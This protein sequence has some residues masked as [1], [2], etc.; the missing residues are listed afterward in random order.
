MIRI[1]RRRF[2]T[3]TGGLV[4]TGCAGSRT[5]LPVGDSGSPSTTG[6]PPDPTGATQPPST[7]IPPTGPATVTTVTTPAD[8]VPGDRVVVMVELAGGNDA[9]NTVPPLTGTYRDLR[10]TL[11]LPESDI[12]VPSSFVGHGLHPS[13]APIMPLI[14][15]GMVATVAGIGFPDPD[16][17]HFVSTD[18]WM[19]ADRMDDVQGWLGRWLDT[20]PDSPSA[21][22]ATAL[23]SGGKMLLGAERSGTV[24]DQVDA[25][26]FPTGLSNASIRALSEPISDDPLIAAAQQAYLTSVGAVEEFDEIADAVRDQVGAT[27]DGLVPTGGAFSTGL[28]VAAQLIMG[29]VDARVITVMGGGFDTHGDQRQPH[30]ELLD[31]LALGLVDFW[32]TLRDAGLSDR[33]LLV[34]HSEFGRRVRENASAGCDHG[35]AGVSFVMGESVNGALYGSIDTADLLDGDLRPRIDPRTAFTACLDWL[36]GDVE[37]I[38]GARYDEI[39]LLA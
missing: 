5:T 18:R 19:R 23:G 22:G 8:L 38:L 13:L 2:I 3:L 15:D 9:V 11:A 35:A 24:I 1:S 34:T 16:R 21:L 20:L 17:S 29:D 4:V 10:P 7:T 25:F 14:D 30:A 39:P 31:D 12:V 37:R 32:A 27:G 6:A 26:A 36:G 33:V 28:A